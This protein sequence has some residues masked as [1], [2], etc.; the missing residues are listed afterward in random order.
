MAGMMRPG[1][2]SREQ[3]KIVADTGGI[4]GVWTHL[5]DTL[6]EYAQNIKALLM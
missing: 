1:L 3:A 2:I 5:A 6:L 4:I